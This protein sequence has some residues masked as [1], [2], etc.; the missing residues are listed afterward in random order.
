VLDDYLARYPLDADGNAHVRMQ[1][2]EVE[3]DKPA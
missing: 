2:L 3:A 1:R